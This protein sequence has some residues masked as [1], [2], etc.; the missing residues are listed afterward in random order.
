[1]IHKLSYDIISAVEKT[2]EIAAKK[3]FRFLIRHPQNVDVLA[4]LVLERP[5]NF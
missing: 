2:E 3:R 4:V 1:M 5:N